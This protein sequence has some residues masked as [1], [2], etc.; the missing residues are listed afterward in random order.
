MHKI[1]LLLF[2]LLLMGSY[3][4][5]KVLAEDG[6]MEPKVTTVNYERQSSFTCNGL[7]FKIPP[8]FPYADKYGQ[9]TYLSTVDKYDCNLEHIRIDHGLDHGCT[10]HVCTQGSFTRIKSSEATG[11]L[12]TVLDIYAKKVE[13]SKKI[14]G[15][16]I[17]SQCGAH[18]DEDKL[19]WY[20]NDYLFM[21][22]SKF[23]ESDKTIS[24]LIKSANSYIDQEK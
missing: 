12:E 5:Q 14:D 9:N 20:D 22:G 2:T 3:S 19:V 6:P 16:L 11:L 24:E 4:S 21:I 18:C 10:S 17:P 23:K 13:L 15:Y 7:T 8:Y 1:K